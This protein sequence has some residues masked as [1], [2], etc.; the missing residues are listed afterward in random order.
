[1][2]HA[3]TLAAAGV[4]AVT[5]TTAALPDAIKV[6]ADTVIPAGLKPGRVPITIQMRLGKNDAG[7]C[8]AEIVQGVAVT[9]YRMCVIEC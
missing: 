8:C 2:S 3:S 9:C 7:G 4:S 6:V 1:M 5:A